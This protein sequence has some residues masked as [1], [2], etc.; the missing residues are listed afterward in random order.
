MDDI[1]SQLRLLIEKVERMDRH[2]DRVVHTDTFELEKEVLKHEVDV[3]RKTVADLRG[4]FISETRRRESLG[5]WIAGLIVSVISI[6]TTLGI[7]LF[8]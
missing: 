8:T 7:A 1:S 4:D 5:R 3:V 6:A 2:L